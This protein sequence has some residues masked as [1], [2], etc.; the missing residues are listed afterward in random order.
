MRGIS[1]AKTIGRKEGID[2]LVGYVV[3]LEAVLALSMARRVL[4]INVMVVGFVLSFLSFF[5]LDSATSV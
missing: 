5:F 3:L 1:R 4:F 2:R